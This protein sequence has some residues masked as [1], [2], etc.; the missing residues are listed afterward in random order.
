[1][2]L[3]SSRRLVFTAI[4]FVYVLFPAITFSQIDSLLR[5]GMCF[6]D[7]GK[8]REAL[9]CYQQ[10]LQ[11][12]PTNAEAMYE[13]AYTFMTTGDFKR[14][15]EYARNSIRKGK[16]FYSGSYAVWGSSLDELGKRAKALRVFDEGITR[17]PEDHLL[18]YNK[19]LTLYRMRRYIEAE[20]E[21]TRS[22]MLRPTHAGSHLL[23]AYTEVGLGNRVKA[24]FPLYIFLLVESRTE[25]S[26][27]AW[28]MLAS[29]QV[30]GMPSRNFRPLSLGISSRQDPDSL[31]II[32]IAIQTAIT[33]SIAGKADST[34]LGRFAERNTVIFSAFNKKKNSTNSIWWNFYIPLLS[35]IHNSGNTEAFSYYISRGARPKEAEIWFSNNAYKMNRFADWFG[36]Q[37]YLR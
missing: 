25:R 36:Q 32:D 3:I 23:L 9:E 26:E 1:M 21:L 14:A 22:V 7:Q 17:F 24:M 16:T 13:M 19:G 20:K 12:D 5:K 6:H 8:Y 2:V 15:A 4:V 30:K 29:L 11:T 34:E 18:A 33:A 37:Q 27:K 28:D 31:E 35:E 10:V